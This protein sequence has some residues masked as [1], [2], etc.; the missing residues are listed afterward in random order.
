MRMKITQD[1][2]GFTLIESMIALLVLTTGV[3]GMA[4]LFLAGMRTATS[5]PNELVATQKAAEAIESVFS[6]RDAHTA[7]WAQLRNVSDGGIFINGATTLK[8]SGADGILNT[9]DD[10][11]LES[12]TLPGVDGTIGTGD[13]TT[14]ALRGFTREIR[15]V[16]LNAT[17]RQVTVT[18]TYPAGSTT[19]TY[20]LTCLIS[21]YA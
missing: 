19:Q 5:A 9:A 10:G 15:I 7:T 2:S 12:V 11:S 20:A 3:V 4:S 14:Q 6:A 21:Q 8:L 16:Q 13:D 1:E 17:L 18:I